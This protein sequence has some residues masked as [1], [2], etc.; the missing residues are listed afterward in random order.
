MFPLKNTNKKL[1][2]DY[3]KSFI[4]Y[5]IKGYQFKENIG[6]PDE[7]DGVYIF[8]EHTKSAFNDTTTNVRFYH[9][10]LYCGKTIDL[11]ERFSSH[12][13]KDDLEKHTNLYIAVAY[14]DNE[15]EITQ[16]ENNLLEKYKFPYN[17]KTIGKN[18]GTEEP[19]IEVVNL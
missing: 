12:H 11:R 7:Q 16:L 6:F 14:C 3:S 1:C 9:K 4:L 2:I 10:M 8:T 19:I 18:T 13:H 17:N 15:K 5:N